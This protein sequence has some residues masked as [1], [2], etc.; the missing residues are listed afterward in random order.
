MAKVEVALANF[1]FPTDL[2]PDKANFRFVVE[3]RYFTERDKPASEAKTLPGIDT[4]YECDWRK[5]TDSRYVGPSDGL[6]DKP[7]DYGEFASERLNPHESSFLLATSHL[8]TLCVTVYDVDRKDFWD[9]VLEKLAGIAETLLGRVSEVLPTSIGLSDD[10]KAAI[11]RKIA[12][13]G[14]RIIGT[15]AETFDAMPDGAVSLS[16]ECHRE[17]YEGDYQLGFEVS[18]L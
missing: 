10:V 2:H 11:A 1:H 14:D 6:P 7:G 15:A 16:F 12:G 17:D 13:P 9:T 18:T 8:R 5:A 4:Y 3:I